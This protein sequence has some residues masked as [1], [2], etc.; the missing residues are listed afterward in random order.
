EFPYINNSV[1]STAVTGVPTITNSILYKEIGVLL[2]L[3]PKINPDGTIIMRVT[4]VVSS[5]SNT[6]VQISQGVFATSFPT[7]TV[8]TTVI[9][10]D[11]ESVV[12]GGL[13]T[14]RNEKDENKIPWVGDLP[15][16][17]ALFRYR[18][19]RKAKTEL[20][21]ILT[22]HIIRCREDADRV[23]AEES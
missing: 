7:Q 8:D 3:T 10:G 21:F 5:V 19:Q 11:G 12:I 15:G 16:V 2:Q 1:V 22:P 6:T 9:A 13:I 14:R 20:I 18:Q 23:L 4:P 17:G